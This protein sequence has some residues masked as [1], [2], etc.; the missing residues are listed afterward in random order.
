MKTNRRKTHVIS[1]DTINKTITSLCDIESLFIGIDNLLDGNIDEPEKELIR[2][3]VERGI[4][5]KNEAVEVL[6][7]GGDLPAEAA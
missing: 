6:P 2:A 5:L 3:A 7:N 4:R 1:N